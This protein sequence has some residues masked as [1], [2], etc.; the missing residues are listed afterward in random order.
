MDFDCFQLIHKKKSK[1]AKS[2]ECYVCAHNP[3]SGVTLSATYR[4]D[5]PV[6]T[7][8]TALAG[9]MTPHVQTLEVHDPQL[10]EKQEY[11]DS[12]TRP[13]YV[14]NGTFAAVTGTVHMPDISPLGTWLSEAKECTV[15]LLRI[16]FAAL[17]CV[18]VPELN[19][20]V[21][22]QKN[23]DFLLQLTS[24]HLSGATSVSE[25][26]ELFGPFACDAILAPVL[27]KILRSEWIEKRKERLS[28]NNELKFGWAQEFYNWTLLAK[29]SSGSPVFGH[30]KCPMTQ[31]IQHGHR[32][33]ISILDKM[34]WCGNTPWSAVQAARCAESRL[35][36]ISCKLC[37]LRALNS[38][39]F[40]MECAA[41]E[42]SRQG[43]L[44][45]RNEAVIQLCS[46][47]Y[48]IAKLDEDLDEHDIALPLV[49]AW[50]ACISLHSLS[51]REYEITRA[52]SLEPET[53]IA[54]FAIDHLPSFKLQSD[55]EETTHPQSQMTAAIKPDALLLKAIASN[56]MRSPGPKCDTR[57]PDVE[58]VETICV[59]CP[60]GALEKVP[61]SAE[62]AP[63]SAPE[64]ALAIVLCFPRVA[65]SALEQLTFEVPSR[66][67]FSLGVWPVFVNPTR[68]CYQLVRS[69]ALPSSP[70]PTY[71][72]ELL[73]RAWRN[74]SDGVLERF[75][76]SGTGG[77][78]QV[79]PAH[80]AEHLM[81][82][83]NT[84]V[85]A[86]VI[87]ADEKSTLSLIL[88]AGVL[89]C[90]AARG[91]SA[92]D[93]LVSSTLALAYAASGLRMYASSEVEQDDDPGRELYLTV[94]AAGLIY[95][96]AW[97]VLVYAAAVHTHPTLK[98]ELRRRGSV[99]D[100]HICSALQLAEVVR[101]GSRDY[102]VREYQGREMALALN[103]VFGELLPKTTVR[104]CGILFA[105]ELIMQLPFMKKNN[106]TPSR[107]REAVD[108]RDTW[109]ARTHNFETQRQQD[110]TPFVYLGQIAFGQYSSIHGTLARM[111]RRVARALRESDTCFDPWCDTL[112]TQ[113]EKDEEEEEEED[114]ED[115]GEDELGIEAL[116]RLTISDNSDDFY[117][118]S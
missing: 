78:V 79:A 82:P 56:A 63:Q 94:T 64:K 86:G 42:A 68:A 98:A 1:N 25:A 92:P 13:R 7:F 24:E 45:V 36:E 37:A 75:I 90:F 80:Y 57:D 69:L 71:V 62:A 44:L 107:I 41:A 27:H 39:V 4:A 95:F 34:R 18:R 11:V 85:G 89:P 97:Y 87:T 118:L 20:A 109:F 52:A 22:E 59:P 114:R 10:S 58:G 65:T 96:A 83:V 74:L 3:A 110:R 102:E 21:L 49:E 73:A 101:E 9:A 99:P 113:I 5:S 104:H 16:R 29:G 46:I 111:P 72:L 2:Q 108:S 88:K 81:G 33:L 15:A 100:K 116:L 103:A 91:D 19:R 43:D 28:T 51:F 47:L 30:V 40:L 61:A 112:I 53:L 66:E 6:C 50:A 106:S 93:R 55:S 76:P 14:E 35:S 67:K 105:S 70:N 12:E 77:R 84:L 8:K 117:F 60:W 31:S 48:R 23:D 32:A 17:I 54:M 115:K 26:V 38:C